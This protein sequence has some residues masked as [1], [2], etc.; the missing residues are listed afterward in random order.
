MSGHRVWGVGALAVGAMVLVTVV[1]PAVA[2]YNPR[3]VVG[4]SLAAPSVAHLLGTND[5]G[6]DIMSQLLAGTR[7]SLVTGVLAAGLAAGM[8]VLVGALAALAG[9]WAD[10]AARRCL[11]VL[12]ALPALPLMILIAAL[13]GPSRPTIVAVIA[14]AGWPPIARIVRSQTLTLVD[15]GFVQA[16]RGLGAGHLHVLRRHVAG[17]LAP[18]VAASF[19]N[20]TATAITLEAGLAFLGLG[21][22]TAI[23]WASTLQRALDQDAVY[24]SGAWMWWVLPVGVLIT[25]TAVGLAL[26]GMMLEP[27]ANPRLPR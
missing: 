17:A 14:F 12:L 15:R 6:Q 24:V 11:D 9:G 26:L 25:L 3:A 1:G 5:A 27:R 23:S 20:W 8:G 22:P 19:V 18:L 16:A 13:L 10:L 7:V 21:D 4:P 2:P